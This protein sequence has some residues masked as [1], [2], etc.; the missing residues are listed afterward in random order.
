M[1]N[2]EFFVRVRNRYVDFMNSNSSE[3]SYVTSRAQM[4]LREALTTAW[5]DR[6]LLSMSCLPG[7][8]TP[9]TDWQ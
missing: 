8:H 7:H 1:A 5:S 2:R 9:G 4:K 3:S 6:K